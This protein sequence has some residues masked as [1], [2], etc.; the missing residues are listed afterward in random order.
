MERCRVFSVAG[1]ELAPCRW[2]RAKKLVKEGKAEKSK[3]DGLQCIKILEPIFKEKEMENKFKYPEM[4]YQYIND[5]NGYILEYRKSKEITEEAPLYIFK[6]YNDDDEEEAKYIRKE[7]IDIFKYGCEK[8]IEEIDAEVNYKLEVAPVRIS[9]VQ[10]KND[11]RFFKKQKLEQLKEQTKGLRES[12]TEFPKILY[13][14]RNKMCYG[15]SCIVVYKFEELCSNNCDVAYYMEMLGKIEDRDLVK[16]HIDDINEY[17]VDDLEC[18]CGDFC[19]RTT[20]EDAIKDFDN[21]L[22][23]LVENRK[24]EIFK[25]ELPSFPDTLFKFGSD[26]MEIKEY[27]KISTEEKLLNECCRYMCKNNGLDIIIFSKEIENEDIENGFPFRAS[28]VRA[29]QDFETHKEKYTAQ[30]K[31]ELERLHSTKIPKI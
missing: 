3:L 24:L 2:A 25:K 10:A 1:E 21:Y 13:K 12:L 31:C 27:H 19:Y 20:R 26:L 5:L 15:N 6:I 14:S 18:V 29:V 16:I 23:M 4:L 17:N 9:L 30:L 7:E 8:P 11:E 28:L 22:N